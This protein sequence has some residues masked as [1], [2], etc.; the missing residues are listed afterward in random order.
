MGNPEE[1]GKFLER[2]K[3]P[4][5][6]KM[7]TDQLQELKL[8]LWLKTKQTKVQDQMASQLNSTKHLAKSFNTYS[9]ETLP[10]SCKRQEHSQTHSIKLPSHWYQ[11]QTKI[12]HTKKLQANMLMNI[13]ANI[14][15]KILANQIQNTLKESGWNGL[16]PRNARIFQYWQIWVPYT[17][18]TNQRMK[19]IWSSQ[20]MQKKLWTKF[21]IHLW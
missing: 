4:R 2:Y 7:W 5:L 6:K 8:K 14:H 19:M 15:N 1:M 9:S 13:G 21:N 17:T 16:Y 3:H 20:Q 12:P 18:L 11:N 10:K